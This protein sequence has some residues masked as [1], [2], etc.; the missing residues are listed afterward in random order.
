MQRAT[1]YLAGPDVFLA[2]ARSIGEQK[3]AICREFGFK[4][5][6]P[7]DKDKAVEADPVEIFRANCALMR[8]ADAGVFNLTPFR[9]PSADAGTVFELGFLSALGKPLYGYSSDSRIYRARVAA[10][11]GPE[12][13]REGHP[14]DRDGYEIENF[15]LGDNLMIVRAIEEAGGEIVAV[16]ENTDDPSKLLA[17]VEAFRACL[18]VMRRRLAPVETIELSRTR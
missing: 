3:K 17:A 10:V 18:D 5:L 15:V 14:Y 11:L 4:G 6:F 9:G 16:E 2:D 8:Q 1:V 12:A 7:L 13:E